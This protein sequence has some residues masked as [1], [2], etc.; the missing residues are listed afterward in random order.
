LHNITRDLALALLTDTQYRTGV[1]HAGALQVAKVG[2]LRVRAQRVIEEEGGIEW[3]GL[4]LGF[5]RPGPGMG[6]GRATV[7]SWDTRQASSSGFHS[8]TYCEHTINLILVK[9]TLHKPFPIQSINGISR[10]SSKM[11]LP[12]AANACCIIVHGPVYTNYIR[13]QGPSR[14]G[15]VLGPVA[16][17]AHYLSG[18]A[19]WPLM[20]S[21]WRDFFT[22]PLG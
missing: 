13:R 7:T 12:I 10:N 11:T 6:Q 4:V 18:P 17:A 19:A 5:S 16:M 15:F 14:L 9:I 1:G 8:Y 22:L 2:Q 3:R 20:A 21:L